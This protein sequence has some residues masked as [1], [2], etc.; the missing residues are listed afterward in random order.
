MRDTEDIVGKNLGA[1][2]CASNALQYKRQNLAS[3]AMVIFHF[4]IAMQIQSACNPI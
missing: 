1:P 2:K 3:I 4:G